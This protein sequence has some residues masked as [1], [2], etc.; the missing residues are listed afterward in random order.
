MDNDTAIPAGLSERDFVLGLMDCLKNNP[1]LLGDRELYLLRNLP[2]SGVGFF[3]LSGFYPDFIVWLKH[4]DSQLIA[5]VDPKGLQHDYSLN[6]EKIRL[7]E[8]IKNI[9]QNKRKEGWENIRLESYIL[10]P[11][12]Y[13]DLSK[14]E[15]K[16]PSKDEYRKNHVIFMEDENWQKQFITALMEK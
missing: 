16:L 15:L 3:N 2:K 14:K 5:F 13:A 7:H 12:P 11:T 6:N 1:E 8:D 9:E 10:S 4:K